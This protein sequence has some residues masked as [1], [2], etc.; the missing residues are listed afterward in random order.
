MNTTVNNNTE[1]AVS[2]DVRNYVTDENGKMRL[3]NSPYESGIL[4]SYTIKSF[5]RSEPTKDILFAGRG[6]LQIQLDNQKP[7]VVEV[8]F[9]SL[10]AWNLVN[11]Q[12]EFLGVKFSSYT[13][14]PERRENPLKL[15]KNESG[16]YTVFAVQEAGSVKRTNTLPNGKTVVHTQFKYRRCSEFLRYFHKTK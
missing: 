13:T 16:E 8:K 6:K 5:E 1:K 2:Y 9:S 3:R 10:M 14:S 12:E 11:K 4:F 7:F 15:Y